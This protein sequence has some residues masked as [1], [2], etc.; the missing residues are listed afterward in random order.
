ML[1]K[2]LIYSVLF[3]SSI[4][5]NAALVDNGNVTRDTATQLDWLDLNLTA[6][7]SYLDVSSQLAAGGEFEGWRFASGDEVEALLIQFGVDISYDNIDPTLPPWSQYQPTDAALTAMRDMIGTSCVVGGCADR[8]EVSG[9][10]DVSPLPQVVFGHQ[11]LVGTSA[12]LDGMGNVTRT[13]IYYNSYNQFGDLS[14][15]QDETLAGTSISSF[16]VQPVPIPA[17]AWLFGSALIALAGI[18]RKN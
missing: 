14:F 3:A 1:R 9:F 5:V 15:V 2:A 7:R 4:T 18:K 17:A 8:W 12:L 11:S 10:I 6:G 13:S 16:L